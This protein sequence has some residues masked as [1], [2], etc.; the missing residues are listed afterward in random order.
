MIDSRAAR[1]VFNQ[2]DVSTIGWAISKVDIADV[3]TKLSRY[4]FMKVVVCDKKI[5]PKVKRRIGRAKPTVSNDKAPSWELNSHEERLR[6]E[7]IHGTA[8]DVFG[9]IG[10]TRG[11]TDGHLF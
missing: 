1:E 4:E 5:E 9:T 8:E 11:T 10:R 2:N 7:D 6:C 3:L